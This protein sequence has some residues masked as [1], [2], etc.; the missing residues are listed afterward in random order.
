MDMV[1]FA[2]EV[3]VARW[4]VIDIIA[5]IA[6]VWCAWS[7]GR[8]GI[9]VQL[10]GIV[11]VIVGAWVAYRFSYAIGRWFNLEDMP[12]EV[13]FVV[14]LIGVMAGVIL[15]SHL[16]TRLLKTGGLGGPIRVLG[17]LF[18]M[19]KGILLAALAVM[20]LEAIRPC[21]SE[22]NRAL[23]DKTTNRA[24]SYSFLKGVG[25]YVFP[26]IVGGVKAAA[27]DLYPTTEPAG[28]SPAAES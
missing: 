20:A 12:S 17:A 21:L 6:L 14:V 15:L 28:T 25:E 10:S 5:E 16:V 7:G 22:K 8:S 13:L 1:D 26:Y 23:F 27:N 2:T 11:G 4:N 24:R 3:A 9:L 19:V 18:A